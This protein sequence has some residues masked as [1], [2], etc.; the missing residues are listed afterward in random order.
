LFLSR[1][2]LTG[3]RQLD[4]SMFGKP[5]ALLTK[6]FEL[7]DN[8]VIVQFSDFVAIVANRKHRKRVYMIFRA[9]TGHIG[10]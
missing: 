6:I 2:S 1:A 5:N 7:V 8:C 10:P 9:I 4:H 3:N